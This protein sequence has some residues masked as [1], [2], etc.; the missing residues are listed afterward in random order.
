M[1]K[2]SRE[3]LKTEGFRGL[4]F[5]KDEWAARGLRQKLDKKNLLCYNFAVT[6]P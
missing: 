5:W 2:R 6:N 4:F 3:P 1:H